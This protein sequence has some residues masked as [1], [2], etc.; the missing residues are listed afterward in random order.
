MFNVICIGAG[1]AEVGLR[2]P[3]WDSLGAE[4]DR[5]SSIGYC[6]SAYADCLLEVHELTDDPAEGRRLGPLGRLREGARISSKMARSCSSCCSRVANAPPRSFSFSRSTASVARICS[7]Y[8]GGVGCRSVC[9]G[10][11]ERRNT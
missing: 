8:V 2:R 10:R 9:L 4:C 1:T 11:F 7:S 3:L 6:M 5:F